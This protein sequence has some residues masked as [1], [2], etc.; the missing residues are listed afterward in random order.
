MSLQVKILVIVLAVV[1]L[2]AVFDYASQ[3][4]FILPSFVEMEHGEAQNT[5]RRCVGA[6]R[7]EI[8]EIDDFT[9]NWSSSDQ[10]YQFMGD[11]KTDRGVSIPS[12]EFLA[13]TKGEINLICICDVKGK[14][15]WGQ[16]RDSEEKEKIQI[17]E[18]S[19]ISWFRTRPLLDYKTIQSSI[20][21]VFLTERGPM[22]I[23][24]R[25]IVT[26][27]NKGPIRGAFITGRYL[28]DSVIQTVTER[29]PVDIKMWN[30]AS[31]LIPADERDVLNHVKTET[32]FHIREDKSNVLHVYTIF[33]DI[34]GVPALLIRADIP[35]DVRAKGVAW[36]VRS[37]FISNFGNGLSVMLVLLL[38]LRRKVVAPIEELTR[39]VVAIG[40]NKDIT[41]KFSI[42][43]NDE[44]GILAKEF[45]Y[46]IEQLAKTRE[47]LREQSYSLG[48]AETTT[49]MLDDLRKRASEL[50]DAYKKLE[51]ANQE[52]KDFAHIVSHDLKAPLRGI[53]TVCDWILTDSADKLG[54]EGKEQMN[55]LVSRVERMHNLI[56]GVLQYSRVGC[57]EEKKEQVDLN[58]VVSEVIDMIGIPGDIQ[59]SIEKEL[60]VVECG[61]VKIMQ[62]FGN[63]L[64][65]AVKHMDKPQGHVKIDY[66]E[67]DGFWKFSVTDN[68]PGIEEEHFDRIFRMFQ[69]LK[70][71]DKFESTGIGLTVVKKIVESYGGRIWVESKLGEGSTFY[72]TFPKLQL[73][74]NDIKIE[75]GVSY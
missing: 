74:V 67:E 10:I 48:K 13:D 50:E 30:I 22:L 24:S 56:G 69:T 35:R 58:E 8:S 14:I 47:K 71:R 27:K 37:N 34:K 66:V 26:S 33:S 75:A 51:N 21:G 28:D 7:K 11:Q 68:G 60:P 19:E 4:F 45:D 38:L 17:D 41:A 31:D 29:V 53:R 32:Q 64:G 62:V 61:Q 72:F 3:R 55:L 44:I 16:I 54:E 25:P 46:M 6:F 23:S 57:L 20:V 59:L 73:Q 63:L 9:R 12:I 42:E 2:Y 49:R 52:L 1:S 40:K 18:L 15:V 39:H 43:R 65:N 70:P 5:M 36:L